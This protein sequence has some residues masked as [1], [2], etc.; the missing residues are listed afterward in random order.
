VEEPE[1]KERGQGHPV[2][3]HFADTLALEMPTSAPV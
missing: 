3:C 2:A 1:L